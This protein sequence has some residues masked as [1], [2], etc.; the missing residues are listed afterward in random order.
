MD[1]E[2]VFSDE[3]AK[4]IDY[5]NSI[6]IF[7]AMWSGPSIMY[8]KYLL[9]KILDLKLKTT[10]TYLVDIDLVSD[11]FVTKILGRQCHGNGEAVFFKNSL[12]IGIFTNKT[13][14]DS[15]IKCVANYAK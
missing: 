3:E 14:H 13:N 12:R 1:I 7:S 4:H 6:I 11:E 5:E 9:Q 15:F 2:T 10:K 8:V